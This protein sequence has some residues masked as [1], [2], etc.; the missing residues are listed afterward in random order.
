MF[1]KTIISGWVTIVQRSNRSAC[2]IMI[3][4][5]RIITWFTLQIFLR[6]FFRPWKNIIAQFLVKT[7]QKKYFW[8]KFGFLSRILHAWSRFFQNRMITWVTLQIFQT[9][10]LPWKIEPRL[11]KHVIPYIY[12]L[13]VYRKF[14]PY[15]ST[16][17]FDRKFRPYISTVNLHHKFIL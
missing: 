2:L 10:P 7:R 5:N 1:V 11:K 9:T 17:N 12:T 14:L 4:Q 13:N 3:F 16:V 8:R 15:I 6:K